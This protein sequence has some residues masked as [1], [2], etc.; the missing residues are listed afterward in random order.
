MAF[1]VG[2]TALNHGLGTMN[3]SSE[4]VRP[5]PAGARANTPLILTIPGDNWTFAIGE[6][7]PIPQSLVGLLNVQAVGWGGA[8]GMTDRGF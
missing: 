3:V 7:G 2:G 8:V 6:A 1:G 4:N 5:L